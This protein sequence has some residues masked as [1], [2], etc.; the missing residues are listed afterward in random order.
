MKGNHYLFAVV[1]GGGTL[2]VDLALVKRLVARGHRV[3][4][5]GDDTMI[6]EVERSG[7]TFRPWRR[8]PNRKTRRPEDDPTRDWE[9]KTPG[10]LFERLLFPATLPSNARY[11]GPQ[12]DDPSWAE[13]WTPP[14]GDEPLVLVG[15]SSTYQD[16]G[17]CLQRIV[18]ALAQLPV[19]AVVTTGPAIDPESIASTERVQVVRS[20]PHSEVLLHAAAMITHGGHGTVMKGLA[21]SV[22]MLI[23]PHGRDQADNATRVASRGAGLVLSRFASPAA[24]AKNLARLLHEPSF[25]E[26]AARL[27]ETIRIDAASGE[28]VH[29]LE[30][31]PAPAECVRHTP[32][33]ITE[34]SAVLV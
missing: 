24:I 28:A 34:P 9:V 5:L 21:S 7:A 11:V 16:Q 20:A 19:R 29:E 2:P 10:Q 31:L 1:D 23:L 18:E 3:T 25:R 26:G 13:P 27:G 22:P 8:A 30:D 33:R 12:L 32:S 14:P 4:V 17:A 6:P 15:L